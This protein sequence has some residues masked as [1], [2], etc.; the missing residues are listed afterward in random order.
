MFKKLEQESLLENKDKLHP[1]ISFVYVRGTEY[2]CLQHSE[3][4]PMNRGAMKQHLRGKQHKIDFETGEKINE[5][6]SSSNIHNTIRDESFLD[7]KEKNRFISFT[8]NCKRHIT[9]KTRT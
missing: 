5:R 8:K 7:L 9:C 2:F 3:D 6:H 4:I 1:N